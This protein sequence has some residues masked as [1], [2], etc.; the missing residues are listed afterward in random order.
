MVD[1]STNS[2]VAVILHQQ[3]I[4]HYLHR[5]PT[6]PV[7]EFASLSLT[8]QKASCLL[9]DGKSIRASS[10]HNSKKMTHKKLNDKFT[11]SIRPLNSLVQKLKAKLMA[12]GVLNLASP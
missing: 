6:P 3:R 2:I 1:T 4:T 9:A 7:D 5:Q 11:Q 12:A 10:R 8:E